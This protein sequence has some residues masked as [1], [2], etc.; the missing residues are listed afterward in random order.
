MEDLK[1]FVELIYSGNFIGKAESPKPSF[2]IILQGEQ[3]YI[4]WDELQYF[5]IQKEM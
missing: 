1:A 5:G 4:C 3:D 2:K